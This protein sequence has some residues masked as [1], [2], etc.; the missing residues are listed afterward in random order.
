M[1]IN[2][3]RKSIKSRIIAIAIP[4]ILLLAYITLPY[5]VEF[6]PHQ[7]IASSFPL[8]REIKDT[9]RTGTAY[10]I[11][12][13]RKCPGNNVAKGI[14]H[15]CKRVVARQLVFT[16]KQKAERKLNEHNCVGYAAMLTEACNYAFKV[17]NVNAVCYHVRGS[18]KYFGINLCSIMGV[19][20]PF[21]KDHDFCIVK[22]GNDS[23]TLD[24]SLY[25]LTTLW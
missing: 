22:Y 3:P 6:V 24:A 23:I 9:L 1:E 18:V 15:Y 17:N 19:I 7:T 10:E 5:C 2:N 21:F 20:S 8:N 16:F 11:A 4:T 25:N 13:S 14:A 12:H